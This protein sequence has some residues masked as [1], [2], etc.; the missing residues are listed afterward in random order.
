MSAPDSKSTPRGLAKPLS[1]SNGPS[2]VR[3]QKILMS[4]DIRPAQ[5]TMSSNLPDNG[6]SPPASVITSGR[7]QKQPPDRSR[8]SPYDKIPLCEPKQA[9]PPKKSIAAMKRISKPGYKADGRGCLRRTPTRC[10]RPAQ[11]KTPGI[12]RS[13]VQS[14]LKASPDRSRP[15]WKPDTCMG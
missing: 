4:G 13:K 2:E 10:T 9:I 5:G 11:A 1:P 6:H 14:P 8:P 7:N 15:D 12:P 3:P